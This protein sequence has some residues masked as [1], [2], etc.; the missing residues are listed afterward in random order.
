MFLGTLYNGVHMPLQEGGGLKKFFHNIFNKDCMEMC[1]H[2]TPH[3]QLPMD[4][5]Y[6]GLWYQV[7]R[8]PVEVG[9]TR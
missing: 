4:P 3:L 8:S 1:G 2:R 7:K 6:K 5:K 9:V